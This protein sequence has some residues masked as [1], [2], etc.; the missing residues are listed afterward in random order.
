[1]KKISLIIALLLVA[2]AFA[3]KAP[4][5]TKTPKKD[6][7]DFEASLIES[8]AETMD[9]SANGSAAE[10]SADSSNAAF[11]DFESSLA[12]RT[13]EDEPI[14]KAR[15]ELLEAIKQKATIQVREQVEILEGMDTDALITL[16]QFE[17]EHTFIQLN[18]YKDLLNSIIK[19]YKN[20]YKPVYEN[21][22]ARHI[23]KEGDALGLY[24]RRQL[25][26]RDSTQNVYYLISE[27]VQRSNQLNTQEKKK[28]EILYLIRTAYDNDKDQKVVTNLLKEYIRDYRQD[29]DIDWIE[30]CVYGPLEK[31]RYTSYK[32]KMRKQNKEYNIQQKLYTGGF[33]LNIGM[34]TLGAT[35]GSLYR[36]DLFEPEYILPLNL[37]LYFQYNRFALAAEIFNSGAMGLVGFGLDFG[38]VVYDSRYFKVRPYL[39][40][41]SSNFYGT[42]KEYSP[43]EPNDVGDPVE[44]IHVG[45]PNNVTLAV[46][47][48]FKFATAYFF[49]SAQ[50]LV[51]F[52]LTVKA[53]LSLINLDEADAKGT[54]LNGFIATGL[55]FYFW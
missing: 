26:K 30:K 39:G 8:P 42:T 2:T 17:K 25:D 15:D 7:S 31:L 28:L 43:S 4:K 6:F 54:A 9:A 37:E 32:F 48:D 23:S 21:E 20:A 14:Y 12:S 11:S 49:T 22:D 33:G 13:S 44:G 41:Y 46:N 34:T 47:G 1:M 38:Y 10:S 27:R 40:L 24:I 16:D 19:F 55:G 52:A 53:G 29:P 36:S 5:S 3:A 18:M 51:S 50:K 45:I 35:I